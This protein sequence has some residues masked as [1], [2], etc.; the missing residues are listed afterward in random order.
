MKP[1]IP[2]ANNAEHEGIGHANLKPPEVCINSL[3]AS[4][5]TKQLIDTHLHFENRTSSSKNN[6][7]RR[8]PALFSKKKSDP[9]KRCFP[10]FFKDW[11]GL[12]G[13]ILEFS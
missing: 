6:T 3:P 13:K 5:I 11:R 9:K 2:K 1:S 4:Q 8:A 12:G 10:L 7:T